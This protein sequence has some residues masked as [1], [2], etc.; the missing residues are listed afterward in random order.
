MPIPLL[1]QVTAVGAGAPINGGQVASFSAQ[2]SVAGTGA[3]SAT[4]L[5][6][7]SNNGTDW[8]TIATLTM[9]GTTRA[10]DGGLASTLWAFIRG[11]VTAISGTS[12][13]FSLAIQTRGPGYGA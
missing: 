10:V 12:A 7:G 1:D 9:S 5:I 2:A 3:V 6:E 8:V 11:N 13:K 4:A